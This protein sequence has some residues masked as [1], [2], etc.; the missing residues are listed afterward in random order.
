MTKEQLRQNA[1][2]MLAFADGKPI[3]FYMDGA[4][5]WTS[6]INRIDVIPHRPTPELNSRPW[7]LATIPDLPIGVRVK[8]NGNKMTVVCA[9]ADY[10]TLGNVE[11]SITYAD[12]L[13]KY[14]LPNGDICGE[15]V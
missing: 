13:L 12:L 9:N 6:A 14:T 4:W 2:A 11:Q 5:R 7:S 15:I 3:Q 8:S 1:A 10:V